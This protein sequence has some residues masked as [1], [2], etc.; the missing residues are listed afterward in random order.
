MN[1]IENEMQVKYVN[2]GLP[3]YEHQIRRTVYKITL[4]CIK[5][6]KR[7]VEYVEQEQLTPGSLAPFPITL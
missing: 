2:L 7:L 6:K 3:K 4:N 5:K 1:D